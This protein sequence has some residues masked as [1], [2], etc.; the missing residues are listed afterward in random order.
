MIKIDNRILTEW[1]QVPNV[2]KKYPVRKIVNQVF[3]NIEN[4]EFEYIF[5]PF[6]VDDDFRPAM[7]GVNVDNNCIVATD[8]HIMLTYP[9]NG[10]IEN[11]IYNFKIKKGEKNIQKL[12]KFIHDMKAYYQVKQHYNI[13][14]QF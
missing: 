8:A 6:T 1:E 4:E 11:G 10:K 3:Q 13:V 2:W 5:E 9:N 7:S 12:M 14:L